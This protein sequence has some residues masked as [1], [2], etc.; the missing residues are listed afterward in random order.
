MGTNR[1]WG[2]LAVLGTAVDG[3]AL[4][5]GELDH[6]V[7]DG[8]GDV[9]AA[10]AEL[11]GERLGQGA[12]GELAGGE[13]AKQSGAADGGGGAGDD[14]GRRMRR[15]GNGVEKEGQ[16]LLSK[17]VEGAAVSCIGE[18]SNGLLLCW[19]RGMIASEQQRGGGSVGW[20]EW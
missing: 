18:I 3:P 6:A 4:S 15:G 2:N 20:P 17:V 16:R 12:Q 13:G 10:R 14:E 8:V 9:D 1:V 11:A 5:A 7:D 19:R